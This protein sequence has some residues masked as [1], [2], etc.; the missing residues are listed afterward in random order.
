MTDQHHDHHHHKPNRHGIDPTDLPLP[1]RP[2]L[3]EICPPYC[4]GY[5]VHQNQV[6]VF[7]FTVG[8][9]QRIIFN[10]RQTCATVQDYTLA[11]WFSTLPYNPVM[12]YYNRTYQTHLLKRMSLQFALQ[13]INYTGSCRKPPMGTRT[14]AVEPGIYYYNI[15]NLTGHINKFDFVFTTVDLGP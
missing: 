8:Q 12:F 9:N 5:E 7:K 13:D 10:V 1:T 6:L 11:C 2:F 15:Q 14:I 3:V 4:M